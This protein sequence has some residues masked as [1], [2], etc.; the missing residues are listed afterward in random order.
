MKQNVHVVVIGGGF[1]VEILGERRKAALIHAPLFDPEGA[2][3]RG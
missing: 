2:R 3:M 1:E